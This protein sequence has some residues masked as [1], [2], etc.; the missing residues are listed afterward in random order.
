MLDGGAG[1]DRL[2]GRGAT[3]WLLPGRDADRVSCGR[4]ADAVWQGVGAWDFLAPDCERLQT[5]DPDL[6]PYPLAVTRTAVEYDIACPEVGE[7][8]DFV[9]CHGT[10]SF[11]Q[12]ARPHALLARGRFSSADLDSVHHVHANLTRLGRALTARQ[13]GV[14][15]TARIRGD[16]VQAVAWTIRL[17]S[18]R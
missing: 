10:M 16:N 5:G 17:R 18:R 6:D 11:M 15:A 14:L 1:P 9:P 13:Q 2:I 7:D 12:A 3:D 8:A 4:R